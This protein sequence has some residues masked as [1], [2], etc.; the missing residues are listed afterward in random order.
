MTTLGFSYLIKLLLLGEK[1]LRREVRVRLSPSDEAYDFHRSLRLIAHR[2]LNGDVSA[3]EA[4]AQIEG[5]KREP[6]RDSARAGLTKLSEWRTENPGVLVE[7]SSVSFQS[8]GKQF[9][10]HF[11]PDLGIVLGG[12]GTAIHIWN[13]VVPRL[14]AREA[15]AA[16]S[17]LPDAYTG[18]ANEPDDFAILS[19]RSGRLIRL[20][21]RPDAFVVGR[22]LIGAL[23]RLFERAKA[24]IDLP[25]KSPRSPAP[26]V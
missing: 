15:C 24:E 9:S 17:L 23:E 22:H 3:E 26:T 16:L 8:P 11:A 7:Y 5:I 21:D 2:L 25:N 19:L 14:G 12:R 6:E 1:P 18:I 20:S 10:I 13:N 4:L